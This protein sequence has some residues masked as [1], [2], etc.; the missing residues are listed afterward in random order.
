MKLYFSD[1]M[2]PRKACAAARYLAAPVE[3]VPV[4]LGKGEHKRPGYLAINPNGKVPALTDGDFRLWEANAI[5]GY[6]ARKAGS[7]FL[8]TDDARLIEVMRWLSWDADHFSNH[9]GTLYFEHVIKAKFGIGAPDAAAV[10][11][12]TTRLRPFAA[13]LD[14][15]LAGRR[16]LVGEAPTVADFAV[17][18]TLPWAAESRIPLGD[19]PAVARWHDRLNAIDAWRE[20]YPTERAF[21]TV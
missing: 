18:A 11:E 21:A 6:L 16:W 13:V 7:D 12:A 3:F 4:D 2:N 10:T 17:A 14:D 19:Y 8:P 1:T 15:H 5:M 20:P 9:A